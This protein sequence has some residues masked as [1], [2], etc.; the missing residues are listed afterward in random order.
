MKEQRCTT[1]H[2]D[3]IIFDNKIHC[4]S[5]SEVSIAE[6]VL[7]HQKEPDFKLT[8]RKLQEKT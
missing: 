3:L 5:N 1:C 6:I 4:K 8:Y 2:G 7:A